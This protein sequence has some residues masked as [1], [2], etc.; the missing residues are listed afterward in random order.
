ML[1][2]EDMENGRVRYMTCRIP[3][4]YLD[5][6]EYGEYSTAYREFTMT[7]RNAAEFFGEENLAATMRSD[8]NDRRKQRNEVSVIHAVY[9]RTERDDNN[10][11]EEHMPFASVYNRCGK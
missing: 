4:I 9:P 2:D 11:A 1:V 3:E 8:L 10:P 7:L 6:N 5:V